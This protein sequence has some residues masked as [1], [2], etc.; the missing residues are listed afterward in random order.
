MGPQ[1]PSA[2]AQLRTQRRT[3]VRGSRR[4]PGGYGV[5]LPAW[6]MRI[7]G[8]EMRERARERRARFGG[9]RIREVLGSPY[10][11]KMTGPT[12]T[13]IA[14]L[15]D[16]RASQEDASLRDARVPLCL[17]D[18]CAGKPRRCISPRCSRP[19]LLG[20]CASRP[21]RRACKSVARACWPERYL[22]SGPS[23]CP[24]PAGARFSPRCRRPSA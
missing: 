19:S 4:P 11:R 17:E 23:D 24:S 13:A 1:A 16:A 8:G 5:H 21:R 18:R 12:T 6:K 7:P 20:R 2:G 22:F 10:A 15:D 9:M 3:I 14:R